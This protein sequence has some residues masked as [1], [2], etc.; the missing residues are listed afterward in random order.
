MLKIKELNTFSIILAANILDFLASHGLLRHNEVYDIVHDM[1][2]N[3]LNKVPTKEH[4]AMIDGLT[5]FIRNEFENYE[6]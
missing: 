6:E 3:E 2:T 1:D 5:K 4:I